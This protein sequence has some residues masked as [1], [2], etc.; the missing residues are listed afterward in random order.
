MIHDKARYTEIMVVDDTSESLLLLVGILRDKGYRV[1]PADSGKIALASIKVRR[2]D[3]ILLDVRMPGM[4]GFEVC[5]KLK[6]D[7][8]TQK[9]PVI[10][11]TALDEVKDKVRGFE[12]GG[13]DFITKPFQPEEVIARVNNQLDILFLR[14]ELEQSNER[15]IN[16]IQKHKKTEYALYNERELLK[17]TLLS[18]GDGVICTDNTGKITMINE[19]AK[20]LTEW[21]ADSASGAS[22]DE[23]FNII[24]EFTRKKCETPLQK[25]IETG[26]IVGLA[27][28]KILISKNGI[29]RTIAD[30]AAPIRDSEGKTIGV[31]LVFRDVTDEK[32]RQNEIEF[33]SF[34]DQL[35]GLYN[36]R[37]FEAELMRLDNPRRLPLTLMMGDLNG[38][39]LTNDG[40]G[41]AAG[42]E[43]LKKTSKVLK[44][45]FRHDDI[46]C[47]Y[48]GD[49]FVVILPNTDSYEA[50]TIVMR[51][52]AL[53]ERQKTEYGMLS[54][55]FGWDTKV[56]EDED[57]SQVLKSAED[58]MY[59]KKLLES[60]SVRS[61]TIQTIIT[62]LYEK[63]SREEAHSKR[64]SDLCVR[65]GKIMNLTIREISN[66]KTA[67]LLHDIGKI[68][69]QDGV[70]DKPGKL[71]DSEWIE[72]KRHPEIGY[73]ILKN[74]DEM[75]E[76]TEAVL[77]HHER[78][79]GKGYPKGL[80]G[81]SISPAAR[82][83]ALADAYDTMVS[84]RPYRKVMSMEDAFKEIEKNSG[85][86]FDPQIINI[87]INSF[88]R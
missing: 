21:Y 17:T 9:I 32:I 50:E 81:E 68:V 23:V 38:L 86:Q 87:F 1:R 18:I 51:I 25:V 82:I 14:R 43:L 72:I 44:H 12:L 57:I 53:I 47:R 76:L 84:E 59:K 45:C 10:F 60:P 6:A 29:V 85:T 62:T 11:V 35:T 78:W 19:T 31:V 67:G 41:H 13:A 46:I 8:D 33:L 71:T 73:R 7:S 52:Q 65:I 22:F 83:I 20:N 37:Y 66:L 39:K 30:S 61:A 74:I 34:H 48:G 79:D 3:L 28:H 27:N 64:V 70:L 42:D 4:D 58:Y 5:Q 54:I 63:S 88:N 75:A 69:I 49:E 15:L 2:P 16:E 80:Q 55:S 56:E 24:N 36:R 77:G 26:K 40:F